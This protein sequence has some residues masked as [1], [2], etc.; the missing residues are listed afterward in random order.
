[1][2]GNVVSYVGVVL[3]PNPQ[4]GFLNNSSVCKPRGIVGNWA[5][6]A[7]WPAAGLSAS[8][9]PLTPSPWP[10]SPFL[11]LLLRRA[12]CGIFMLEHIKTNIEKLVR[13]REPPLEI[14]VL[15]MDMKCLGGRGTTDISS[16]LLLPQTR[17][18]IQGLC[19][20]TLA[21]AVWPRGSE[22][23]LLPHPPVIC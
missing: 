18:H 4:G 9:P 23:G 21:V 12:I 11:H 1:M 6:A 13:K 8:L 10:F 22:W 19:P 17:R 3:A 5:C 16:H 20:S 2:C 7:L 14:G 15:V